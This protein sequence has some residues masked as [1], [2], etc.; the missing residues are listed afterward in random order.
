MVR[1]LVLSAFWLSLLVIGFSYLGFPLLVML[2]GRLRNRVV[3]KR[4]ITPRM[5]L[6]I[7]AYNEEDCIAER[8]ENALASDYPGEALE[9]I[10][11]SDGSSDRTE[12]IVASFAPRGVRLLRLP[13]QGKI[14]ALT[15]AVAEARGEILVFSD[16]NTIV[17]PGALR[18]MASNFADASV[19]G[20]AGH[21]GYTI[22]DGSDSSSHGENGYWRYDT[23]IKELE[24]RTGSVVSAHGGL[25]A[26]RRELF[27]APADTA[28]TDDFIIST[29]V[30]EQGRRLVFEPAARAYEVAVPRMNREFSRRVRL[31]TRGLRGVSLRRRLLN[32]AR[33]GFYA[34]VLFS[35]KILRRLVPVALLVLLVSSLYL[36][37]QG[38]VFLV[39]LMA[40]LGIYSF[41]AVGYLTRSRRVGGCRCFYVPFFFCMANLAALVALVRFARGERVTLWQPQRHAA[42]L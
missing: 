27:Q 13:R 33:Y 2:V 36:S 39:A 12:E 1:D 16:A 26:L 19:G 4:P 3:E 6:I 5:S 18:A 21:T 42:Q 20:V 31:M 11:A 37:P 25:Y 14:P 8:L 40:Q 35:H 22:Q 41:A 17:D 10:V 28:V 24:S 9:I 15:A 7:A 34:V 23:W 32:P 38:N 30:V 29:G